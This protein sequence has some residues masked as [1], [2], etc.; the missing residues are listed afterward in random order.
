M[1]YIAAKLRRLW[2]FK[3]VAVG[4]IIALILVIGLAMRRESPKI[5]IK[6]HQL[7]WCGNQ[8]QAYSPEQQINGCTAVIE[9]GAWRGQNLAWAFNNRGFAR[10]L[11]N[12]LDLALADFDEAIRLDAQNALAFNNRGIAYQFRDDLDQAITNYNQAILLDPTYA[13]AFNSRG[14]AYK[15]KGDLDRAIIDYDLAIRLDPRFVVAFIGRGTVYLAKD[16]LDHA[17][18]DFDQSI[19]LDR[20]HADAFN[21]RGMAYLVKGDPDRAIANYDEAVRLDSQYIDAFINRGSAYL[22]KGDNNRAIVDYSHAIQ[23]DPNRANIYYIRG[24][25]NLYAGSLPNAASDL[26]QAMGYDARFAYAPLWLDIVNKRSNVPSRLADDVAQL[27]MTMWP[28]P[29]IRHYLGQMTLAAVLEAADDRSPAIKKS[30]ICEA[31][32]FA[33]QLAALRGDKVEATHLFRLV[34]AD[35]GS[36]LFLRIL[37]NAEL[38]ALRAQP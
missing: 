2:K 8:S 31:N 32:F 34:A 5:A 33:G 13:S 28:G 25:A 16:Q 26:T 30:H 10:V 27:D 3:W 22:A 20:R 14:N 29:I 15:A 17:I 38:K 18:A 9:S 19:L 1:R 37:V 11:K 7:D 12:D 35:C 6:Q 4:S 21:N 36:E 23:L 24:L